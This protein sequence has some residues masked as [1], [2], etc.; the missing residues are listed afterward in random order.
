M[1]I[2]PTTWAPS[3]GFLF[4]VYVAASGI[5]LIGLQSYL[6]AEYQLNLL[7]ELRTLAGQGYLTAQRLAGWTLYGFLPLSAVLAFFT[8]LRMACGPLDPKAKHVCA[9]IE[10][11][12]YA[13]GILGPITHH[14]FKS[15]ADAGSGAGFGSLTLGILLW[16]WS[17]I[18]CFDFEAH[19]A[20]A[21]VGCPNALSPNE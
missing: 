17:V 21:I 1:N 20:A 6:A 2:N 16:V 10:V 15:G 19:K 14:A 5:C 9:L 11:L 13:L 7:H 18:L 4:L 12:A 8:W 3:R